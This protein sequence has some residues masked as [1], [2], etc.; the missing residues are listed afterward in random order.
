M[1]RC[2]GRGEY[3][4][5]DI[6]AP[7]EKGGPGEPARGMA[8]GLGLRGSRIRLGFMELDAPRPDPLHA[9]SAASVLASSCHSSPL[10]TLVPQTA[11]CTSI[12]ARRADLGAS[13]SRP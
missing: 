8:S 5:P 9:S 11:G 10:A 12:F 3:R 1:A 7:C 4:G 13:V 2:T 6:V